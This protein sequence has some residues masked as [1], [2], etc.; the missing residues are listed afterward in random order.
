MNHQFSRLKVYATRQSVI[1][2]RLDAKSDNS[3]SVVPI[4]ARL[5]LLNTETPGLFRGRPVVTPVFAYGMK[6]SGLTS[7]AMGSV[8]AGVPV[9]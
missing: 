6:G 3:Y 9:L 7:L 5:G 2:Q 8:N 1:K 4:L